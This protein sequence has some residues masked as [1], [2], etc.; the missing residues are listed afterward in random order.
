MP[1]KD[2]ACN[3]KE[4]IIKYDVQHKHFACNEKETIKKDV[5]KHKDFAYNEN[6]TIKKMLD[7]TRPLPAMKRKR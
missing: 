3:E 2:F 1:L 5:V 4:T 7:S 6:E